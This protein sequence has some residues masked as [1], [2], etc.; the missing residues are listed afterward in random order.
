MA[1]GKKVRAKCSYCGAKVTG[2][3]EKLSAPATCPKCGRRNRFILEKPAKSGLTQTCPECGEPI[4]ENASLCMHCG[5]TIDRTEIAESC[6][7]C[8]SRS[9]LLYSGDFVLVRIHNEVTES[10]IFSETTTTRTL[11]SKVDDLPVALCRTCANKK[12]IE[13]MKKKEKVLKRNRTY[14][15]GAAIY[16]AIAS[17]LAVGR[18]LLYPDTPLAEGEEPPHP[19]A[20]AFA[21]LLFV[22]IPS[23]LF[24][25]YNR[26]LKDLRP[27]LMNAGEG[28][29]YLHSELNNTYE[30]PLKVYDARAY[31]DLKRSSEQ[32]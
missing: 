26:E 11:W 8:G 19:Y 7:L 16:I 29:L 25:R 28:R 13:D 4:P 9:D 3:R 30:Y 18:F 23:F 21:A 32:A 24:Y 17:A 6:L 31:A 1:K 2:R 15:K 27:R 20:L 10:P 12:S 5:S 14:M 22:S